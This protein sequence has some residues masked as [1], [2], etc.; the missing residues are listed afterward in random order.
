[1]I[2]GKRIILEEIDPKNIEQMRQWRN[3]P[4]LRKYFREFKDISVDKQ[5]EWYKDRGNNRNDGHIYFQIMERRIDE[6][7]H[8]ISMDRDLVGCTG[9]HYINW[10]LRSAEFSIFLAKSQGKGFGRDALRMM[11]DYG[12][13]ECNFDKIWGEVYDFNKALDLYKGLGMKEDGKIRHSQFTD[14]KYCDSVV[15][16]VL[17]E[18]WFANNPI[19]AEID[20]NSPWK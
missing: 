15:L 1:M 2:I 8:P 3:D 4:S 18:E 16:S 17:Q 9:L 5:L 13:R 12:F 10:R 14:G 20:I 6:Q 7:G 19:E 11:F